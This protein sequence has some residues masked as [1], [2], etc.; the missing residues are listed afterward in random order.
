MVDDSTPLF[1]YFPQPSPS[2]QLIEA[3]GRGD[4]LRPVTPKVRVVSSHIQYSNK[5]GG[6]PGDVKYLKIA[7]NLP[8]LDLPHS[9]LCHLPN[10]KLFCAVLHRPEGCGAFRV[11]SFLVS[12]NRLQSLPSEETRDGLAEGFTKLECPGPSLVM[13]AASPVLYGYEVLGVVV[14]GPFI[15]SQMCRAWLGAST[16]PAFALLCSSWSY[17]STRNEIKTRAPCRFPCCRGAGTRDRC[18]GPTTR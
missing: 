11:H 14:L 3:P 10:T 12:L 5:R 2:F 17:L 8:P 13:P 1:P 7:S 6:R 9:R 16:K 18:V 4:A 15:C